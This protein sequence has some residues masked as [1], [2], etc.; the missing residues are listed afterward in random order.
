[1]VSTLKAGLNTSALLK[2]VKRRALMPDNQ[3]TF[4]DQD[5]I[6]FM[7]EEVMIGILPSVLQLHR[8][9]DHEPKLQ[10]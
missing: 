8:G 2:S 10:N 4:S 1:M 6:D 5:L 7:N 3:N 9:M